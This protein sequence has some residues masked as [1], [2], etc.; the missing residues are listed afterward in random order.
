MISDFVKETIINNNY[1]YPMV[2]IFCFLTNKCNRL[3]FQVLYAI[4]DGLKRTGFFEKSNWRNL[5]Q[6]CFE[7]NKRGFTEAEI[8][9]YT[10]VVSDVSITTFQTPLTYTKGKSILAKML[11]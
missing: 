1:D 10:S 2:K 11:A 7:D 3:I 5:L 9:V 6:Q 8:E 4:A